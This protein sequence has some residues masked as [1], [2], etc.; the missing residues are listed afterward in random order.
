M[1]A[2]MHIVKRSLFKA[3]EVFSVKNRYAV[4]L[5]ADSENDGF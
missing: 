4:F 3:E 1:Y 5:V 2:Y